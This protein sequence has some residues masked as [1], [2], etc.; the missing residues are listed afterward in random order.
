MQKSGAASARS[1]LFEV[2]SK[3]YLC[4][5]VPAGGPEQGA[6][7]CD[8]CVHLG[9]CRQHFRHSCIALRDAPG[10]SSLALISAL[11]QSTVCTSGNLVWL[12]LRL[13]ARNT[14]LSPSKLARL[15]ADTKP[16]L[17]KDGAS[18]STQP[19]ACIFGRAAV[20]KPHSGFAPARG[21]FAEQWSMQDTRQIWP[22][23]ALH[24]MLWDAGAARTCYA[25]AC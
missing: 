17:A 8:A 15:R 12:E 19:H 24:N 3:L 11:A 22:Q 6:L 7:S 20:H 18:P 21:W 1:L 4:H 10:P 16:G 2:G 9:I 5:P 13:P 14:E 25:R 23:T